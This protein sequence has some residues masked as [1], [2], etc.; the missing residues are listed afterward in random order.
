MVEQ[1]G[2]KVQGLDKCEFGYVQ[3]E[4]VKLNDLLVN[5]EDVISVEGNVLLDVWMSYGDKVI[6]IFDGFEMVV[7]M[8]LCLYVV[9]VNI[10][11]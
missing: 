2:G 10:D 5:I 9:M 3:V 4:V 8:F 6:V 7:L 11:K 1:F